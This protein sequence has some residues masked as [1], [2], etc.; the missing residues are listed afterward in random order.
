MKYYARIGVFGGTFDPIHNAHID[1]ARA[2]MNSASLDIVLFVVS[3]S[4]PHK[5]QGVGATPE[6]RFA[7]VEAALAAEDGLEPSDIEMRREGPSYTAITL[8]ALEQEYPSSRLFLILGLDSLIDLPNWREP[9]LILGKAHI[10]AV[11]RPDE[12]RTIPDSLDGKYDLVPFVESDISS[13]EVRQ[14]IQGGKS[15]VS[16]VSAEVVSLFEAGGYYE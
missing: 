4:P 9:E 6:Q 14:R 15:V 2:A 16:M 13:S 7:M 3:A 12:S 8:A 1:I 5:Q 11:S 10:L